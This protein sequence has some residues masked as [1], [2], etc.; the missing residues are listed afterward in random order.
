[1]EGKKEG[2]REGGRRESCEGK[3]ELRRDRLRVINMGGRKIF[4]KTSQQ[5]RR[6]GVMVLTQG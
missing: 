5:G 2:S 6:K 1:M 3:G 4:Q